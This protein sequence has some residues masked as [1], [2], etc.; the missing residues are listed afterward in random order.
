MAWTRT[1]SVVVVSL[2]LAACSANDA[3]T[4]PESCVPG[5]QVTCP[6][7]GGAEGVQVCNPDGKSFGACACASADSG[8]GGNVSDA[9][10]PDASG[11]STATG[12]T[13]G[14]GGGTGGASG[15]AGGSGGSSD[16]TQADCLVSSNN[17]SEICDDESFQVP[18]PTPALVLVCLN[19]NGGMTYIASNTGPKM[20][21]GIQ[22]CQGWETSQPPENPWDHLQ[23]LFKLQCDQTQKVLDVDLSGQSHVYVGTHDYPTAGA[24][25]NTPVCLALKK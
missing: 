8:T 9:G 15:G 19:D 22:R 18:S 20:S 1:W 23:Y 24:G 3:A 16:Y 11:G 13:G 14:G 25:H 10:W 6:C 2:G 5:R 12:G 17:G 21:D 4:E 7:P